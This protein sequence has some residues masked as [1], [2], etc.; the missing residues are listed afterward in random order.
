MQWDS[1][2]RPQVRAAHNM[3]TS[4]T[5]ADELEEEDALEEYLEG[6]LRTKQTDPLKFW[7]NA[8]QNGTANADLARMA[9]DVL[10]MPG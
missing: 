10:S 5:G 7:N 3:F 8:L 2:L 1:S 4:L 9:L 6:P